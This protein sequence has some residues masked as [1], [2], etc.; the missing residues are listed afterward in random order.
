M[1]TK[2]IISI[3]RSIKGATAALLSCLYFFGQIRF[4]GP[5]LEIKLLRVLI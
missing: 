1:T 5:P 3:E 4:I 2:S